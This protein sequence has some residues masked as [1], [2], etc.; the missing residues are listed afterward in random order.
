[1]AAD[2][3]P[4]LSWWSERWWGSLEGQKGH[5]RGV[6]RPRLI[7]ILLHLLPW[8][9]AL[10]PR[11]VRLV[12]RLP[13]LLDELSEGKATVSSGSSGVDSGGGNWMLV[14]SGSEPPVLCAAGSTDGF[15]SWSGDG[16]ILKDTL[17]IRCSSF[18]IMTSTTFQLTIKAFSL[19][20]T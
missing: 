12:V 18:Q 2:A 4:L 10:M 9:A 3:A 15:S 11:W 17:C 19:M 16:K 5:M 8:L 13:V 7:Y 6:Q 14:R 20:R 1:M